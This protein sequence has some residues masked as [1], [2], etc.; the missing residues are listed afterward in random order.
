MAP[1][2]QHMKDC[3]AFLGAPYEE[4]NR[5]MDELFATAGAKHRKY[6]HHWEG[7]REARALFGE[8]GAKAAIIHILRDCRNIPSA[9]D[10]ETGVADQL[11]LVA[12][13]PASAYVHYTEE[14]FAALVKYKIGG[15]MAVLLWLF[16]RSEADL[17]NL[18]T[19]LSR[20][21]EDERT[22]RLHDW[23]L[24]V[25]KFE[26]LNKSPIQNATTREVEGPVREWCDKTAPI[27]S[28]LLAQLP[29]SRFAMVQTAQLITPLSLIDY[30]YVEE[31]KATLTG[32]EPREVARFALPD[33][34][35]MQVKTGFDPSGRAVNFVS[36]QKTLVLGP[37]NVNNVPG[38]GLE[39]KM[40]LM[41][42]PQL[43]IVSHVA[44][45]LYLRSGIHRA[46]LLASLGLK[47]VPCVLCEE[48]QIPQ[49]VGAYPA[50]TPQVLAM[51]RPPL[52]ID[53]L[54]PSL[55]LHFPLVRTNKIFRISAE[56][57]IVPVD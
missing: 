37:M 53:T 17:A 40:V 45:R 24:A 57:L 14:A 23:T 29:K 42:T 39:V 36:S 6:R 27:F 55:T 8:E 32:T 20:F 16:L 35:E 2:Q 26:E 4:V 9:E 38:V 12:S 18:L 44:G 43:I 13:W 28:A 11:G 41:S 31:L 50:F 19:S 1:L 30:E 54:D 3:E 48:E 51:P 56:E 46:Y 22:K 49:V 33:Q 5:W 21:T 15:P 47:E 52:L 25:S 10:Y 34:V 7:V